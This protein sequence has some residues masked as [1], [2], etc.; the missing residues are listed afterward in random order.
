MYESMTPSSEW[1]IVALVTTVS[2][3]TI[4]LSQRIFYNLPGHFSKRVT[5]SLLRP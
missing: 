4:A 2:V 3:S 5:L 1:Q